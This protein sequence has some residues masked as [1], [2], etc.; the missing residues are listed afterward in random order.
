MGTIIRKA[1]AFLIVIGFLGSVMLQAQEHPS[2]QPGASQAISNQAL[3]EQIREYVNHDA[4]LK[5]GYFLFFDE[6]TDQTVKLTLDKIHEGPLSQISENEYFACVD[7][8][9]PTG[10]SY[11]LDFVL[12]GTGAENLT[13]SEIALHKKNGEPRYTWTQENGNWVRKAVQ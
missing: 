11:D 13:V 8:Q 1:S 3:A 7:F 5:G 9:S 12:Q 4:S 10:D 6:Q 2:E